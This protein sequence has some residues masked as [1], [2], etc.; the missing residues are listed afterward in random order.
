MAESATLAALIA[1]FFSVLAFVRASAAERR[2]AALA[3]VN[4]KLDALLQHAGIH[5]DPFAHVPP[6]VADAI[7]R[8]QKI[9]AIKRYRESSGGDLKQAKEFVEEAQRRAGIGN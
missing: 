3:Q 7:K 4:A 2:V 9:E 6:E 1:A 8:G 5:F